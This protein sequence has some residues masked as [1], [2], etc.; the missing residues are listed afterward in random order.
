LHRSN[1]NILHPSFSHL[2]NNSYS[3]S[4]FLC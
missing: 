4:H 1:R 2:I 3:F